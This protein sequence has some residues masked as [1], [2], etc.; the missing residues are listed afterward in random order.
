MDATDAVKVILEW[1]QEEGL[2]FERVGDSDA[3]E[4][5]AAARDRF[6]RFPVLSLPGEVLDEYVRTVDAPGIA[7]ARHRAALHVVEMLTTDHGDGRNATV[8][9]GF[10]RG[11][12]GRAEFFVERDLPGP[13][14]PVGEPLEWTA[15][16]SEGQRS[17]R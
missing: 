5:V 13:P 2:H 12:D 16:G 14:D 17:Q 11:A 7:T 1:L 3:Y 10:R 15:D 9:I 4:P 8:A 6:V